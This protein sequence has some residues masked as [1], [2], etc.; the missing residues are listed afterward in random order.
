MQI[1]G[2]AADA[3]KSKTGK[4]KFIA[5]VFIAIIDQLKYALKKRIEAYSTIQQEF[6]VQTD[7]E[8]IYE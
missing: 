4:Q 5:N 3:T 2:I 6:G 1:K 8:S 7:I